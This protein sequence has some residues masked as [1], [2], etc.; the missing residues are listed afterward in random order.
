M[1]PLKHNRSLTHFWQYNYSATGV[2]IFV[3]QHTH[4]N[5]KVSSDEIKEQLLKRA[6][7][8]ELLILLLLLLFEFLTSQ[9]SARK[10]SPILGFNNQ[11]E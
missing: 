9:L 4:E 1:C 3:C 5:K 10:H 7:E 8:N 11:Q 2:G 6:I